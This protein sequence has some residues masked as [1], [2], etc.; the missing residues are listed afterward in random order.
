MQ[1]NLVYNL[2]PPTVAD[3]TPGRDGNKPQFIVL[4]TTDCSLRQA[5]AG[6][7]SG[8]R[9]ASAHRIAGLNGEVLV[10]VSDGDTAWGAANWWVNQRCFNLENE[11]NG[12]FNDAARTPQLYAASAWQVADWC[13]RY[14]I[15]CRK[16][17]VN[18][19]QPA[20][21]G[22]VLHKEV[23][24]S[25]TAC[26]DGLDWERIIRQAAALL[27]PP[28]P[29]IAAPALNVTP[30]GPGKVRIT[31]QTLRVHSEPTTGSPGNVANTPDGMLHFD[32]LADCD[33]YARGES[34]SQNGVTSDLWCHSPQG[35]Y[36]WAPDTDAPFVASAGLT[37]APPASPP[38]APA[39]T[40][41][42]PPVVPQWVAS[43]AQGPGQVILQ[44][45]AIA[46]DFEGKSPD[47][48]LPPETALTVAGAFTVD[49]VLYLRSVWSAQNSRWIGIPKSVA[50]ARTA[51]PEPSLTVPQE[52]TGFIAAVYGQL[53]KFTDGLSKLVGKK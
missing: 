20:E 40:Q 6:F 9:Q 4:H 15:P 25:G 28:K 38:A 34:V 8:G 33:G 19:H 29:V 52:A 12:N 3:W 21:P 46:H 7:H 27:N 49:G 32:Q 24:L 17:N 23:S 10:E 50:V 39:P 47:R 11:D 36:F 14:G 41:P 16:A 13:R 37:A 22:I 1:P 30:W 51:Q 26:P 42:V 45:G 43:Y 31:V 44:T 35:H 5:D 2:I 18:G 53:R 48:E